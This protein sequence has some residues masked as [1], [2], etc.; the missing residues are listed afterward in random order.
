MLAEGVCELPPEMCAAADGLCARVLGVADMQPP[1]AFAESH[2]L[3]PKQGAT[4]KY[5]LRCTGGEEIE[6]VVMPAPGLDG[7]WSLCI[8]SQVGCR[9]G[10]AFCETGRMGLLRSLTTSEI[11]SQVALAAS[12]LGLRI[13]NVIFMGMGEPLDNVR[14][15]VQAIRVLTDPH[16]LNVPRSHV[17]ISTS[18]EAQHVPSLLDALPAVRLAFSLHAA[19]D[20]LRSELMPIN[21]RVRL[22]ELASAMTAYLQRTKRRVTIQYILLAGVNDSVVHADELSDFLATVGPANRLHINLIP[23][24]PQSGI[25]KFAAPTHASCKAFKTALQQKGL[26]TKIR[27]EKGAEKM[28]ACGQLGNVRL[29]REL[30]AKRFAEDEAAAEDRS[31]EASAVGA[32]AA[33]VRPESLALEGTPRQR[34]STAAVRPL[35]GQKELEW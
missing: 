16:G 4:E 2:P 23:Y 11:V 32:A 21:R 5:V 17:T 7:L 3:P 27:V 10:C 24:N 9:M 1:L 8:S 6:M 19:N 13:G 34:T 18:G 31:E 30:N 26:F 20:A 35:C 25:P 33:R 12:T 14:S 22:S 28:A 29:R 15:V